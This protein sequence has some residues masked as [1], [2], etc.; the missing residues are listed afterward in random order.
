MQKSGAGLHTANSCYWDTTTDGKAVS[1]IQLLCAFTVTLVH[2]S[3]NL[4]DLFQI[5]VYIDAFPITCMCNMHYFS[6][7][8][9]QLILYVHILKY[10]LSI[11]FEN[12]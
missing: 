11:L 12:I 1:S 3:T 6:Y 7:M 5:K 2:W 4:I 8:N 10:V 9:M